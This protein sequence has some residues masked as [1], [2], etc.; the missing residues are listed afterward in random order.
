MV[1]ST[2][3]LANWESWSTW[4]H[5]RMAH[6]LVPRAIWFWKAKVSDIGRGGEGSRRAAYLLPDELSLRIFFSPI[7]TK[8]VDLQFS[9][10][11]L[12]VFF[13][14]LLLLILRSRDAHTYPLWDRYTSS[15]SPS[16][17]P[18]HYIHANAGTTINDASFFF[19]DF[20]ISS[21]DQVTAWHKNKYRKP[22]MESIRCS[23]HPSIF[24]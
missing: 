4:S 13:H 5:A 20:Y 9:V 11:P 18:L 24:A 1:P 15:P 2:L 3:A 22:G 23:L 12:R 21:I 14:I 19:H 6:L 17:P 8:R 16:P 7:A 10:R